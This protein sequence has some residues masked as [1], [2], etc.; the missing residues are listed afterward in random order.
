MYFTN[1]TKV[2]GLSRIA[3]ETAESESAAFLVT[4]K[5]NLKARPHRDSHAVSRIENPISYSWKMRAMVSE[6]RS[7]LESAL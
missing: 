1:G 4:P 7:A 6:S 5:A 2:A 3:R